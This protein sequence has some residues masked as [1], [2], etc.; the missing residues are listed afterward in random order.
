MMSDK[1]YK[2]FIID[3]EGILLEGHFLKL[4]VQLFG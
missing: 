3:F 4:V 1:G 2:G